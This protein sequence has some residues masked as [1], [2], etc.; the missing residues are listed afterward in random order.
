[1]REGGAVKKHV[2]VVEPEKWPERL[3]LMAMLRDG[4]D[5]WVAELLGCNNLG[6]MLKRRELGVKAKPRGGS[7]AMRRKARTEFMAR[8]AKYKVTEEKEE[9]QA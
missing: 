3:A 1:V 5:T 4:C 7:T 8:W 6:V 9:R 2:P